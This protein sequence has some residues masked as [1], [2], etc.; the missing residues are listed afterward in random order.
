MQNRRSLVGTFFPILG[1]VFALLPLGH[2]AVPN[3]I[4]SAVTEART[5]V[6]NTVSPR[7]RSSS[8]L[9]AAPGSLKLDGLMLQFNMTAAQQ[10]ALTRLQTD[11]QNP[12]SAHYHQW[13]TPQQFGEQFGLSADD[14]ARVTSWL[15]A[16]GFTV[17]GVAKSSNF[18]TFSGTAAQAQQAFGTTIHSLSSNGQAHIANLTDPVL[19]SAIASVVSNI[20][21]LNDFHPMPHLRVNPV[22]ANMLRP[23]FT[24]PNPNDPVQ[25][26]L[27]PADFNTIYN[28]NPLL[29]NSLTGAGIG[30]CSP[31]STT[32][33]DIAVLGQVD[34]TSYLSD[35]AA[36]RNAA[37]L[38]ASQ[39]Y[40]DIS[41]TP[42]AP[43]SPCVNNP[44]PEA[45][46]P[47]LEESLFDV[48]WAGAIAPQ[49]KILFVTSTNVISSLG[50]AIVD[51]VAPIISMSYGQ[52]EP[53]I[54]GSEVVGLTIFLQQASLQGIT[55]IGATGDDGATDCDVFV[56]S[57][58][59][60]LAVD[61]PG[62]S[63]F[64]TAIGGTMFDDA[65]NPSSY[66][67]PANGPGSSSA[68]GYIP[69][70][71]WNEDTEDIAKNP[72]TFGAG[73]GGASI[74][75]TKPAWQIG[76]GV[77]TDNFRH[78]PDISLNAAS[79]HEGYLFCIDGSCTGGQFYNTKI[80]ADTGYILGGTS[81]GV[82][83]FASVMALVEE[84]LQQGRLG[85][86]NPN[87]YAM[88]NGGQYDTI[89]HDI[90]SGNNKSPCAVGPNCPTGSIGFDA[91]RYYDLA[92]GW[93]S[94]DAA[95]FAQYWISF[96]PTNPAGTIATLTTVTPPSSTVA[97]GTQVS[98]AIK[99]APVTPPT[100]A[101]PYD[102][103]GSVEIQVDGQPVAA[104]VALVNG[105][106]TYSLSTTGLIAG[107]H[108]VT[109]IYSGDSNFAS[110]TGSA[111]V[112]ITG[113]TGTPVAS[114]T[115][116][117]ATPNSGPAGTAISLG[118]T[119]ASSGTPANTP[120]GTIQ[121]LLDGATVA[122]SVAL[123][124]GQASYPLN[125]TALTAGQH[126][127]S[128]IY[129]GDSNFTGSQGGT[130]ITITGTGTV[131]P[132]GA[133]FTITPSTASVST[134]VGEKVP[135]IVFTLAPVNG[136]T[137]PI[138]LSASDTSNDQLTPAFS[139][140]PVVINSTNGATT[141]LTF[142][143]FQSLTSVRGGSSPFQPASNR[144]ATG[145]M[146]WYAAGSGATLACMFLLILPRRRRWG[147]LLAVLLSVGAI[148]ASGCGSGGTLPTTATYN[149]TITATAAGNLSHT[150]AVNVTFRI[151]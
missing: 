40:S 148:G 112:T 6:Q 14:I 27:A 11:Q 87:I 64:V 41:G 79:D 132:A 76:Q 133:D 18:V 56:S 143:A 1:L 81:S 88:A 83:T 95:A 141:T 147:A 84:S 111:T 70:K 126:S 54:P 37:G 110:S 33:G 99:V 135:A 62:S 142:T 23:H 28:V 121:I 20:S 65:T 75:F 22:S 5:P 13:L 92:S 134:I 68:K 53:T 140:N 82:P 151:R 144:S 36:F 86:I 122:S 85:N 80:P 49:A 74:D 128:V 2:A 19:P 73:G 118:I 12:A 44:T 77:P 60:G 89:F 38:P 145:K 137:G 136:F 98:L 8:D 50:V 146:R 67:N 119:V 130:T 109:V 39:I 61:F 9:G 43:T 117:T 57:A 42:V 66:W 24:N 124:G 104:S 15:T 149:I 26:A 17:T 69:E 103:T 102:P 138:T 107:S 21:G 100:N 106:T 47:D 55:I 101:P 30:G 16:Q 123:S 116:V 78:V 45:S 31:S 115:S 127:V 114:H 131:P 108:P 150:A 91:S 34:I 72:P 58:T 4:A 97:A 90:T 59:H 96:P 113:T 139:V 7:A 120:S 63:P 3:R 71:V 48:E 52:C 94:I 10:A 51:N 93:G 105:Q 32:C 25:Y 35:V 29:G 129:S 46:C 125:T